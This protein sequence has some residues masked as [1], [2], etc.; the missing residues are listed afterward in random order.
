MP[1]QMSFDM[2]EVGRRLREAREAAGIPQN[3]ARVVIGA[4]RPAYSR[5]ER[6]DRSLKGDELIQLADCFHIRAAAITGLPEV[7]ER[8]RFTVRNLGDSSPWSPC[9]S[10]ST[11]T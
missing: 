8:A 9:V 11:P 6:G 5:I 1:Y 2:R 10:A 3:E 7:C 4:S